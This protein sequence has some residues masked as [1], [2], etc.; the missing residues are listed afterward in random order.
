MP[1]RRIAAPVLA[2]LALLSPGATPARAADHPV[3]ESP[4]WL[5]YP[6]GEGPGKG[7]HI[8]LIAAD[9]EYRSE[10]ALPMLAKVLAKHHGFHCTV[11]FSVNDKDEVDPTK[12]IRW[13]DKTVTHNVPG[14]E[15]LAKADLVILFSRLITLPDAQL[16]HVY[17]YLDAGKPVIGIRTANHGF[18]GFDYKK[19]GKKIDF[20]EDILGGSFRNHH[21][22]WMADSTRGI[23]VEKNNDHPVLKGVSGHLGV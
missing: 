23:I 7:K 6:G 21:G 1:T 15:H 16:K 14:I 11:L 13:E 19:D 18:L 8:V 2:L 17:E 3:P 12:K 20:G 22:R 4:L 5:T 9:Q 10:A